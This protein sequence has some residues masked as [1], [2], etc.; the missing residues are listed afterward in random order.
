MVR[1][2]ETMIFRQ[3]ASGVGLAQKRVF[4]SQEMAQTGKRINFRSEDIRAGW[5]ASVL[6]S[7]LRSLEAMGSTSAGVESA[8]SITESSLAEAEVLYD[9]VL[10]LAIAGANDTIDQAAR[11]AIAIEIESIRERMLAVANVKSGNTYVFGG[12]QTAE[13]PFTAGGDYAGDAGVRRVEVAPGMTVDANIPG[14]AAFN[15][16]IDVF[17]QLETLEDNL[18]SNDT[19]A[20]Q[21][22]I[23][24][25]GTAQAQL[26]EARVKAGLSLQ[27]VE[28][29]DALRTELEMATRIERSELVDVEL[30]E[31]L[32][33]LA[34][35][36]FNLDAAIAQSQNILA[37][38]TNR[39][40]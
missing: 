39:R 34:E 10:E 7:S 14:D 13:R 32:S 1:V 16:Q 36:Q 22:M 31:A 11:R 25:I 2:T 28:R 8:L 20:V 9:R 15:D 21:G 26:N 40:W 37:R 3:V 33:A 30:P 38:L 12:Y 23:D 24:D 6:D 4:E 19:Q 18:K 35:A 29:A 5:R 27:F 17:T